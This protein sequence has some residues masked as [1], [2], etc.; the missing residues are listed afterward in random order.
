VDHCR[1]IAHQLLQAGGAIQIHQPNKLVRY[2]LRLLEH[3]QEA[4]QMGRQALSVIQ[5]NRGVVKKNLRMIRQLTIHS[6]PTAHDSQ[7]PGRD[8]SVENS[9]ITGNRYESSSMISS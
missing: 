7:H 5:Q 4:E 2:L 9:R 8:S 6:G 3:P 1:D